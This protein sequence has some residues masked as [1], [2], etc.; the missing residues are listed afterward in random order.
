MYACPTAAGR[1]AGMASAARS[2]WP[3]THQRTHHCWTGWPDASA[4]TRAEQRSAAEPVARCHRCRARRDGRVLCP[5]ESA[6]DH[7]SQG[8]VSAAVAGRSGVGSSDSTGADS[9]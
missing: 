5:V 2:R 6:E 7:A 8:A 4:A 9:S 3:T 1:P